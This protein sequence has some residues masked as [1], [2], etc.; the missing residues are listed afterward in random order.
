VLCRDYARWQREIDWMA[1]NSINMPLAFIGQEYVFQQVWWLLHVVSCDCALD[2][3][4][5]FLWNQ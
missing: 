5:C 4:S 2:C 3:V 1:L